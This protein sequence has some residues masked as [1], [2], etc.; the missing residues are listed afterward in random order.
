MR[1]RDYQYHKIDR[2]ICDT[3]GDVDRKGINTVFLNVRKRSK[4]CVEIGAAC[5]EL[6]HNEGQTPCRYDADE[7]PT[8]NIEGPP[9]KDASMKE[10]D[11]ELNTTQAPKLV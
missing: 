1:Y 11:R 9:Y 6:G 2:D 7:Y 8:R 5:C 10:Q 4:I 3:V